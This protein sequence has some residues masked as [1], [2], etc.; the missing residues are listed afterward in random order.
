VEECVAASSY[1]WLSSFPYG[2]SF[3]PITQA[4]LFF[5]LTP[6]DLLA[7]GTITPSIMNVL[8]WEYVGYNMIIMYAALRTIPQELFDAA[9]IDGASQWK[10]AVYIKLPAIRPAIILTVTFAIIGTFQLFNE[11]NLFYALAPT[12]IGSSY[13]PNL[14][15]YNLAFV[16][17]D[18]NYSAAIAFLLATVVAIISFF[19]QSAFQRRS[20]GKK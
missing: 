14:Y 17:Q 11:P 5:G 13:S 2:P 1:G 10:V 8:W 9:E 18:V 12:A 19:V 16:E 6:P 3:G 4:F 15:A 20:E 7:A